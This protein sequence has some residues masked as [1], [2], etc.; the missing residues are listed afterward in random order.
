MASDTVLIVDDDTV[1]LEALAAVLSK[2]FRVQKA[3]NGEAAVR[4]LSEDP[5]DVIVLDVMMSYPSEGYDLARMLK[6]RDATSRIPIILLTGVSKVFEAR[7]QVDGSWMEC[8]S[9]MT[10]PPN[11]DEL[12]Q[13]IDNL[14]TRSRS[15]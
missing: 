5:P 13:T 8:E 14:I 9:F 3:T 6:G 11:F 10:K 7:S 1:F 2:K 15:T 4:V 12:M